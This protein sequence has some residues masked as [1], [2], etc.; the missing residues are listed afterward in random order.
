MNEFLERKP[1]KFHCGNG[2]DTFLQHD[3]D[4]EEHKLFTSTIGDYSGNASL[5]AK[6]KWDSPTE[7]INK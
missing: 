3:L 2:V 1:I 4:N 5:R 6:I 7:E